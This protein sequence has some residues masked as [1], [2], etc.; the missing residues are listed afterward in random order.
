[1]TE[2][3]LSNT[4][5]RSRL[6][7][8]R[9]AGMTFSFLKREGETLVTVTPFS[10]CKDYLND[11]LYLEQYPDKNITVFGL[12]LSKSA[13]V[14][15]DDYLYLG[16]GYEGDNSVIYP[17]SYSSLEEE[18]TWLLSNKEELEK[19]LRNFETD[20]SAIINKG[21]ELHE[22]NDI[23]IREPSRIFT[24]SNDPERFV[25][26]LSKFW[27][28]STISISL[29]TAVLRCF[30]GNLKFITYREMLQEHISNGTIEVMIAK[31]IIKSLD[32]NLV[33]VFKNNLDT[34]E[35][36]AGHYFVHNSGIS[37]YASRLKI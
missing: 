12:S 22:V 9:R 8:G 31:S 17:K 5:D 15:K 10:C 28:S 6:I 32:I 14:M 19:Y 25:V 1:M 4:Q 23:L 11:V 29:Y 2:F 18:K 24:F 30:M 33:G 7:E 3:N 35:M 20:I 34:P 16:I 27:G 21:K 13:E 37:S 36:Q 26:R